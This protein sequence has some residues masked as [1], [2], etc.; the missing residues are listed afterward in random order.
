[1]NEVTRHAKII[2]LLSTLFVISGIIFFVSRISH[3][4][5]EADINSAST[6]VS[7][8]S[9]IPIAY[10][11][12][13]EPST[14]ESFTYNSEHQLSFTVECKDRYHTVLVYPAATDYRRDILSAVYNTATPCTKGESFT[15][16]IRVQN[17]QLIAGKKYYIIKAHQGTSGNWY[18][19]Y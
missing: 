8:Q 2:L 6:G 12:M 17:N 3:D 7:V 4:P 13:P 9:Q 1:M 15:E 18:D 10:R 14:F 19:P 11:S 16:V 5:S